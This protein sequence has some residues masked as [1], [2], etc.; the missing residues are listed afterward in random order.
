M[1][2]KFLD[3]IER[4]L[5]VLLLVSSYMG[6]FFAGCAIVYLAKTQFAIIDLVLLMIAGIAATH[7]ILRWLCNVQS[8]QR[9]KQ[10]I[11]HCKKKN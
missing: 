2:V 7:G 10:C 6:F 8:K 4:L 9:M 3:A 11:E 5:I 1:I